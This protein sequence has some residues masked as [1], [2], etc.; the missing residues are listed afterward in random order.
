MKHDWS[1]AEAWGKTSA[2]LLASTALYVAFCVFCVVGLPVAQ[3]PALAT[4][5]VGGFVVWI[6]AMCYAV[7]A[8]TP[9]RAWGV[10]LGSA[11]ALVGGS[12]LI[13]LPS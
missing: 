7:L 9:L 11:L 4:G 10:L 8:R 3:Q 2:A 6:A 1:T 12:L 13:G 5:V